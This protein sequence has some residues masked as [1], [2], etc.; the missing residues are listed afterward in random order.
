MRVNAGRCGLSTCVGLAVSLLLTPPA[1]GQQSETSAL[2]PPSLILTGG[3]VFTADSARP[4]AEAVAIRGDRIA[5]VGTTAEIRRL[6]TSATRE[7]PLGGR[8]VIPG[9]NDAH[10][11]L[12]ETAL[13]PGFRTGMSPM[14][15]PTPVQ[16]LDSLRSLASRTPSGSWLRTQVGMGVLSDTSINRASLDR[17]APNHPV[18]LHGWWGHGMVLNSAALRAL[19]IADDARDPLGGWYSRGHDGR[20]TGRADIYANWDAQ[21]RL[22]ASHPET[23]LVAALREFSDSSIRMGVTSVQ[24]MAGAL[25]PGLTARVFRDARLPIRVRLIRWS[26]PTPTSMNAVEWDTV[27]ERIAARVIVDGRKWVPEG[28]PIEQFALRRTAYPGR[29]DWYGRLAFPVDTIRAILAGALRP[30]AP[31]LH[32]HIVGDSTAELVLDAM[33]ALAPAPA[34]RERRVRI[35]HGIPI[36]GGQIARVARLG[37]VIAQPRGALP[38]RSWRAAGIPVAYGSDMLRNPFVH[39]ITV[40]TGAELPAEAVSREEAVRMYTHGSAFAERKEK[41]KGT[42]A[43]GMLA[44]LAVLSQDIFTV[45]VPALPATRSVLTVIGGE[46]VYDGLRSVR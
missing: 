2:T 19:A 16:V 4:W 29:P 14:P 42:L 37:I 6:A 35:E 5:A 39:M 23:A 43:P 26:I 27:S 44:D 30:G 28:T 24:N 7:I 31:Q 15:D 8:V 11:H 46:V 36:T 41:E 18:M 32:I 1:L 38:Y 20:L 33:E 25:A 17:A 13:G 10:D 3:K 34:W 21:R 40:V 12:G 45:P 22:A 9:I